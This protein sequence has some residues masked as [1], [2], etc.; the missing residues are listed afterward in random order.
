MSDDEPQGQ[1]YHRIDPA[2]FGGV[3]ETTALYIGLAIN[4]P[5]GQLDTT[6]D[7]L[8]YP[9]LVL[10]PCG[11]GAEFTRETMPRVSTPCSCGNPSHWLV[12]YTFTDEEA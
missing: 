12:L 2:Y 1:E 9:Q 3:D 6:L 4:G 11:F 10:M 5:R 8:D 7:V